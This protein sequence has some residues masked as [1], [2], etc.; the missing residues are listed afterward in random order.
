MCWGGASGRVY[1]GRCISRGISGEVYLGS[2]IMGVVSGEVYQAK[3]GGV[4]G[5]VYRG[6]YIRGGGAA[7]WLVV[8]GRGCGCFAGGVRGVVVV[9]NMGAILDL[10]PVRPC[11]YMH[12]PVYRI[13]AYSKATNK[14]CVQLPLTN[15]QQNSGCCAESRRSS[16][17]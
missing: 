17:M 13:C 2:C 6:R 11:V 12:L 3:R 14:P 1:L 15:Q 9:F 5:E 10:P 16:A 4:S 7:R 8:R